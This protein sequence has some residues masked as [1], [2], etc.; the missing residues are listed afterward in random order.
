MRIANPLTTP[1][2]AAYGPAFSAAPAVASV[3]S[4]TAQF[5][6]AP[7]QS[8]SITG[9]T[10][11]GAST[12]MKLY[13]DTNLYAEYEE[14]HA[15]RLDARK[16][17]I[18]RLK[19]L[20]TSEGA[21]VIEM[22]PGPKGLSAMDFATSVS[23][24]HVTAI[25][26]DDTS[27]ESTALEAKTR[28]LENVKVAHSSI[29]D[30]KPATPSDAFVACGAFT[31]IRPE[32]RQQIFQTIHQQLLKPGGLFMIEE[33]VFPALFHKGD[34]ASRLQAIWQH[35]GNVILDA[36]LKDEPELAFLELQALHSS[37]HGVGDFKNSLVRFEKELKQGG[38]DDVTWKKTWPLPEHF[39]ADQDVQGLDFF[40]PPATSWKENGRLWDYY[41]V[42]IMYELQQAKFS[43]ITDPHFVRA[44]NAML[45][46][47]VMAKETGA[48]YQD[49]EP[50][51]EYI[52]RVKS[53]LGIALRRGEVSPLNPQDDKTG[54][55]YVYEA[56]A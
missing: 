44:L 55:V 54:G 2:P 47:A 56:T 27:T 17:M 22:G 38:F 33:E 6:R 8:V 43:L 31:D 35:H 18:E 20:P 32:F 39:I 24:I 48:V 3:D 26:L 50:L 4:F 5:G 19:M 36:I 12:P 37:M 51:D 52:K 16:Y 53:Q 9:P 42:Q 13:I 46:F 34:E 15:G 40:H 23:D 10:T 41:S 11:A 49:N 14:A 45:E 29:L 7:T 28:G 25:D 1:L 30:Y 21:R